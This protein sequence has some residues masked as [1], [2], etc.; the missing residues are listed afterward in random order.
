MNCVRCHRPCQ[1]G[2][3]TDP[4]ARPFRL[5]KKGLC[6]DCVVTHFLLCRDCESLRIGLLIIGIEMLRDPAIQ[7]QFAKI[8]KA[9]RSELPIDEINWDT[10]IE[11]WDLPFP[12]GYKP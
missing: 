10:V 9:G 12:K 7:K 11:Q 5:A 1:S 3:S 6:P 8:L 4:E 2:N